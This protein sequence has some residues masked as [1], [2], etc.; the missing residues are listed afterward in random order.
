M[1]LQEHHWD[2]TRFFSTHGAKQTTYTE[3]H[4]ALETLD[5]VSKTLREAGLE[6]KEDLESGNCTLFLV[7][8]LYRALLVLTTIGRDQTGTEI[9]EKKKS[10]KWLLARTRSRWPV[11]GGC[12]ASIFYMTLIDISK[13]VYENILAA[14]EAMM[15]AEAASGQGRQYTN[16]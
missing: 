16:P 15:M 4:S 3:T 14:K 6:A 10:L 2:E 11:A 8:L 9:Q 12:R 1:L 13:G 5:R 7:N